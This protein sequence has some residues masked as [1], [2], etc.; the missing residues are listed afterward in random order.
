MASDKEVIERL[1]QLSTELKLSDY[2]IDISYVPI[3]VVTGIVGV[4]ERHHQSKPNPELDEA[5]DIMH[6]HIDSLIEDLA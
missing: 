1:I 4:L 3:E 5:I 2:W 6:I